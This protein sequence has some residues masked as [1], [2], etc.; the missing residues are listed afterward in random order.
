MLLVLLNVQV[1]STD[2]HFKCGTRTY[3]I[4]FILE[5]VW[6]LRN[7]TGDRQVANAKYALQHNVGLGG[8][9]VI[10]IY[11]K[12]NNNPSKPRVGYNPAVEARHITQEDYNKAASKQKNRAEFLEAKL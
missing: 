9:V 2:K 6:Q 7:W 11:K 5:L 8:A 4:L 1:R 10:T 3:S 12:A